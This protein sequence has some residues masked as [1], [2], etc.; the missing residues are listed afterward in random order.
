MPNP[1]ERGAETQHLPPEGGG[2]LAGLTAALAATVPR[3]QWHLSIWFHATRRQCPLRTVSAANG[4]QAGTS[5]LPPF[6]DAL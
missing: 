4:G 5:P 2:I 6:S 3:R 1:S